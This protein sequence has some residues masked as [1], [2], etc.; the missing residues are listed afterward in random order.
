MAALKFGELPPGLDSW[1]ELYGQPKPAPTK[2]LRYFKVVGRVTIEYTEQ[3]EEI[4]DVDDTPADTKHDNLI[5]LAIAQSG[6]SN[7]ANT[8]SL[9]VIEVDEYSKALK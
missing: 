7:V 8:W 2:K 9:D 6:L 4:I 5:E 1:M 3:V